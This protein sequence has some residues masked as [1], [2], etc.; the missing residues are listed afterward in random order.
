MTLPVKATD[1]FPSYRM[2]VPHQYKVQ[3][4]QELGGSHCLLSQECSV[5]PQKVTDQIV[6]LTVFAKSE[7]LYIV[8]LTEQGQR[9]PPANPLDVG[10]GQI[11][12]IEPLS[13]AGDQPRQ[14]LGQLGESLPKPEASNFMA[15]AVADSQR[16]WC[17]WVNLICH[18]VSEP[19]LLFIVNIVT[20]IC[21]TFCLLGASINE[22]YRSHRCE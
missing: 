19:I 10:I 17:W 16:G 13:A 7:I 15:V 20:A 14:E 5:Q 22:Q 8:N 12:P 6:E 18:I 3:L 9:T 1:A 4:D 11:V 2:S 21:L